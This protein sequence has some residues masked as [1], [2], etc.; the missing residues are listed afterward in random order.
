MNNRA[1]LVFDDEERKRQIQGRQ[2]KEKQR[3]AKLAAIAENKA[4]GKL[5]LE[6][7]DAKL[8]LVLEMLEE[9]LAKH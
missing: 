7:V 1:K 2:E 4:K 6:D 5:T 3:Q 9:L 8:D